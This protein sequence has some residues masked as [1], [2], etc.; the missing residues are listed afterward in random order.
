MGFI[1]SIKLRQ[2]AIKIASGFQATRVS[3]F[4]GTLTSISS[5]LKAADPKPIN[6]SLGGEG[7]VALKVF[8]L[9]SMSRFTLSHQYV[10]DLDRQ[11][12]FGHVHIEVSDRQRS[13][14]DELFQQLQPFTG[15]EERVG[16]E[17]SGVL[18][19]FIMGNN[20]DPLP[21]RVAAGL[22]PILDINVG[23]VISDVFGDKETFAEGQSAMARVVGKLTG[24]F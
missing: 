14:V 4:E 23:L 5:R 12:F 3:Q 21:W 11:E 15:D 8:Q 19:R 24:R 2:T 18:S 16:A 17:I 6:R 13:A 20:D 10:S 1:K 9:W 7:E 22:L